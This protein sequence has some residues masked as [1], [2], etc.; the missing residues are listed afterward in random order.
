[1]LRFQPLRHV[2]DP[3]RRGLAMQWLL[4]LLEEYGVPLNAAVQAYVGSNLRK[5]AQLPPAAR[6]LSHLV[7]LMADGSRETELKAKA[8]RIDAQGISHP[9][10]ELKALITLQTD[11]RTVL[12]RFTTVGEYGGMFDGTEDAFDQHPIQTFELRTLL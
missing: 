5:L 12:K 1:D 6:T 8:G 7:T 2:D 9:D 11:V 4:D 10:L 3:L